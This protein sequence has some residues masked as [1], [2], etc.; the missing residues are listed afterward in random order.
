MAECYG[1]RVPGTVTLSLYLLFFSTIC[2]DP[3]ACPWCSRMEDCNE[4][5][6]WQLRN[7]ILIWANLHDAISMVHICSSKGNLESSIMQE[8]LSFNLKKRN[9]FPIRR[10]LN[11]VITQ[12]NL[13]FFALCLSLTARWLL[14]KGQRVCRISTQGLHKLP[15]HKGW[16]WHACDNKNVRDGAVLAWSCMVLSLFGSFYHFSFRETFF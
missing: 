13:W 9:A 4:C 15:C 2:P 10:L 14:L 12:K 8:N 6:F 16:Q 3:L 1:K 11:W 7:G 5:S